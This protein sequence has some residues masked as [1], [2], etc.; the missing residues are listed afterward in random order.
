[1]GLHERR[2]RGY[3]CDRCG[4]LHEAEGNEA[5]PSGWISLLRG[6]AS[7]N[8]E[9]AEDGRNLTVLCID[10]AK[11]HDKFLAGRKVTD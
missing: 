8:V 1:M 6:P 4:D 9:K 11:W 5:A 10:C 7:V 3:V 2:V